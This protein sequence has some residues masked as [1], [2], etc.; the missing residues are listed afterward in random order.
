M[1]TTTLNWSKFIG[2][3]LFTLEEELIFDKVIN[4][5]SSF[6]TIYHIIDTSQETREEVNKS[7][8]VTT[9][10]EIFRVDYY[11]IYNIVFGVMFQPDVDTENAHKI[12]DI[13]KRELLKHLK[14]YGAV[15]KM[16]PESQTALIK[17]LGSMVAERTSTEL[18][19]MITSQK[20]KEQALEQ[21]KT[22]DKLTQPE[23][24]VD[25]KI[26][27]VSPETEKK[28]IS[29]KDQEKRRKTGSDSDKLGDVGS[30][31][32]FIGYQSQE[33]AGK[34]IEK[35][36]AELTEQVL[37]ETK[38]DSIKRLL[39]SVIKGLDDK[40]GVCF[41]YLAVS[42]S[43][44]TLSYGM[45]EKHASF[46]LGI[47]SKYPEIIR[48]I[49]QGEDE[50][51]LDAGDGYVVL[52]EAEVGILVSI[53]RQKEEINEI[54]KRFKVVKTMINEFLKSSF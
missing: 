25:K 41:V 40:T 32:D 39:S 45:S 38:K 50:K 35:K 3:C 1:N 44:E 18:K 2:F 6:S 24:E 12:S 20:Q 34:E 16:E 53:T 22:F 4:S 9:I 26:K 17:R 14:D 21:A 31:L 28:Q 10:N 43:L 27:H 48:Q 19:Q 15:E 7:G 11:L 51:S 49:L 52:E 37:E 5:H 33:I 47:L 36:K 30:L 23:K 8:K 54:S 46:V 42:G 13:I 29:Y